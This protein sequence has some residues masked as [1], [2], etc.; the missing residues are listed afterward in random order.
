VEDVDKPGPFFG[1]TPKMLREFIKEKSG[2]PVK[3]NP[4]LATLLSMAEEALEAA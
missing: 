3:G 4:K 2:E 1:Y